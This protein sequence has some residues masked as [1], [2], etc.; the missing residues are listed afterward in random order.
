MNSEAGMM[1]K[2]AHRIDMSLYTS[3]LTT[4]TYML[5]LQL[6]NKQAAVKFVRN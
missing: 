2:G 6:N 5:T 3:K 4:G 1:S